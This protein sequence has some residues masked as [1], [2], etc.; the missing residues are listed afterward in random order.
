METISAHESVR[1]MYEVM[2]ADGI[3]NTFDRFDAQGKRC[4]FC[5]DGLSCQLCSNGPCRI[6]TKAPTGACGID[7]DSMAM[8]NFLHLNIMGTTAYT[9]H[10]KEVAMTLK[11]TGK[12][13][14]PF[15]I[16]D[17]A[18]LRYFAAKLGIK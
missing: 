5:S 9:F 6:S 11:A 1:K 18:K 8:R 3:T 4:T 2:K 16:K 14:T 7:G 13:Q 17:E 10:A 12:G 15:T